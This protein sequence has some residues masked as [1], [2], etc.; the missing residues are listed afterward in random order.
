MKVKELIDILNNND[1]DMEVVVNVSTHLEWGVTRRVYDDTD[2][3]VVDTFLK[4]DQ[5]VQERKERLVI[6]G[7]EN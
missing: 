2:V 1:P 5:G 6:F 4:N 3:S 7:Y